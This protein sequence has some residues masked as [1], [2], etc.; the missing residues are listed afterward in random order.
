MRYRLTD[1]ARQEIARR[2]ISE[3]DI[4][5]VLAEPEQTLIIQPGRVVLQSTFKIGKPPKTYLLR[6]FIDIDS[7][8]PAVVTAY[9]T[10]KVSK[11]WRAES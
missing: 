8:P 2:Y 3:E 6:V 10:S 4:A 7:D 11:Y 1:H 5:K 9:R